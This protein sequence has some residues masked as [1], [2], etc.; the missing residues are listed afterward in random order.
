MPIGYKGKPYT[1]VYLNGTFFKA[2]YFNNRK[3]LAVPDTEPWLMARK[4]NGGKIYLMCNSLYNF[5]Y[6]NTPQVIEN[7]LSGEV[8]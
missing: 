2:G 6:T 1:N 8:G 7:T 5:V 4:G 3:V